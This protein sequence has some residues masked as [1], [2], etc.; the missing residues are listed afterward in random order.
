VLNGPVMKLH[1]FVKTKLREVVEKHFS[2]GTTDDTA[3]SFVGKGWSLA[4]DMEGSRLIYETAKEIIEKREPIKENFNQAFIENELRDII[5]LR[6]EYPTT[7]LNSAL[8]QDAKDLLKYLERSPP[9]S[10]VFFIPIS[11]LQMMVS[12]FT[13]G[14]ANFFN[15][16]QSTMERLESEYSMRFGIGNSSNERYSKI[17]EET[18]TT[19]F[20]RVTVSA[21]EVNK[22]LE[23]AFEEVEAALNVLRLYG[24]SIERIG[25]QGEVFSPLRNI[26]HTNLA[27]KTFGSSTSRVDLAIPFTMDDSRLSLLRKEGFYDRFSQLLINKGQ[28]ELERKIL[29]SIHWY[30]LGI[31]DTNKLDKFV[32]LVIALESI[33]LNEREEP[34]RYHL[35]ERAAFILGEGKVKKRIYDRINE[36]YRIRSRIVHEGSKDIKPEDLDDIF[37]FLINLIFFMI[38]NSEKFKSL[39]DVIEWINELKFG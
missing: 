8:D 7:D 24:S 28:T 9:Q 11:N 14:N 30:G 25:I 23:K 5:F 19:T 37:N 21:A 27:T 34:K 20:S 38:K 10:W 39:N 33:L 35:A 13:L 18:H 15:M 6:Y 3:F 26:Y 17:K 32:K 16:S 29:T 1:D 2:R 12:N 4:I 22:A 31:K 36:L